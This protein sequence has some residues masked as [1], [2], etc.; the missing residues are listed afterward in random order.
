MAKV[1]KK[2]VQK[3][4]NLSRLRL[5]GE[6]LTKLT[7]NFNQILDF[8]K[9]I[10]QVDTTGVTAMTHPLDNVNV[11][12]SDEVRPSIETKTIE[13][14]AP[15]FKDRFFVVPKVIEEES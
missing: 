3:I 9:E 14:I 13:S 12:R 8:V 2:E 11:L 10:G 7:E 4:A 6:E 15:E 1:S 5:E